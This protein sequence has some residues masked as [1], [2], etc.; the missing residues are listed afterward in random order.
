MFPKSLLL[1]A[2]AQVMC[3]SSAV[4]N[5]DVTWVNRNPDGLHARPVIGI[6]NQWPLPAI[7]ANVGEQIT[8]HLTNQLGNETTS[9][10]FHGLFQNG[11]NSMDGPTGVTQCPIGPGETFTQV[12]TVNQPGTYWYHSHNGGQYPDGFR[13]PILIHDP[14]SPYA[15]QYD[16]ELV[17]T[18]SDWYHKQ[19]ADLIP[20]FLSPTQNPSGAEPVPDSAIINDNATTSFA[21]IPGKTYMVRIINMANFAAFFVK[22]DQHEMTIIEVDGVYTVA[23]KTDLIYLSDGQR[24]S[25]LITAKPNADENFAFVGAMDPTMFDTVPP[26]LDLNATGYLV[27]NT[28]KPLPAE[29]PTFASYHNGLAFDDF[30]LVPY[31]KLALFGPVTRQVVLNVNS[32]VTDNQNRFT[33]NNITYTE[34]KVPSL[35]TALSVG[36]AATNPKVYGYAANAQVVNYQDIVEVVVNNFDSGGHPV[37]LHGHNFQIVQRSAINAGVYGGTPI[38]PPATPIRRDVVKVNQGGYITFRYIANN[39]D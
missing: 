25:V 2:L 34:P 24:M 13:G 37:H 39:P 32:G 15:S 12:F 28:A 31:D 30:G 10:H 8:V 4:Y 20:A 7:T 18:L 14:A 35:Y 11:T 16:E 17:L 27:Y 5:W 6:N 22:F 29:A 36:K 3:V 21:M 26:K 9:L 38:N 23:Q 1:A 33:I 19:M